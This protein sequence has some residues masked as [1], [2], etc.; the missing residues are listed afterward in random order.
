MPATSSRLERRTR[1]LVAALVGAAVLAACGAGSPAPTES[2]KSPQQVVRDAAAAIRSVQSFHVSGSM[3]SGTVSMGINLRIE[4]PQT[5][6]GSLTVMGATG[7]IVIV[8]GASYVSGEAFITKIAGAQVGQLIGNQWAK[9]PA[10]SA[11][12]LEADLQSFVDTS[13]FADCLDSSGAATKLTDA[14]AMY[15]GA[16][17]IAVTGGD[18][19]LEVADQ[20]TPYPMRLSVSGSTGLLVSTA[21]CSPGGSTSSSS[22]AST[23]TLNFDHWGSSFSITAPKTFLTAPSSTPNPTPTA[24]GVP[25]SFHYTDPQGRWSATFAGPPVYQATT[26]QAANGTSLPYL[27]AEYASV[28]VDQVVSVLLI[29]S[30]ATFDFT[31]ALNGVATGVSGTVISHSLGRFRG[32]SSIVGIISAPIGFIEYRMV[33]I[34]GVVYSVSTLGSKNPPP[35]FAQ[36]IAGVKFTPH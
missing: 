28:G 8:D 18:T 20:A 19:I 4:N 32:Y 31:A 35:D 12:S 34:G 7:Q 3:T 23:G 29:G 36:F 6:A 13:K 17:V 5:F 1:T 22:T 15:N 11:A 24:T 33:R 25:T 2:S 10:A 26:E 30:N 16:S 21:T 14:I 9:L 27:Y